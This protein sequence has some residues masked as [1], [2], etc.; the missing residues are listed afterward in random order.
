MRPI[1]VTTSHHDDD[2]K[3][4]DV[5]GFMNFLAGIFS[6]I[7]GPERRVYSDDFEDWR[8]LVDD[9]MRRVKHTYDTRNDS[10]FQTSSSKYTGKGAANLE[11]KQR[12]TD[13]TQ[14]LGKRGEAADNYT[15]VQQCTTEKVWEKVFKRQWKTLKVV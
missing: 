11:G 2:F 1:N 14:G 13:K 8:N 15:E 5:Y 12:K 4:R 10:I 3:L 6:Q 7:V 9:I